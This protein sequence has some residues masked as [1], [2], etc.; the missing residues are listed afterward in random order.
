[1]SDDGGLAAS[2]VH[3][4]QR[5]R[6]RANLSRLVKQLAG[7]P[8]RLLP[9]EEV[10]RRLRAVESAGKRL[11]DVPLDAIVGSVGRYNDF[12]REFLPRFDADQPRWVGVKMAM[13]GL[14]G[15]PPIDLYRLGDAYFVRDGNHR[16]SVARQ[17]GAR[18]IQAYVT[19][20][21]TRVPYSPHDDPD[22]LI[23][24][25][26]WADFLDATRLDEL[27]PGADLEV[28]EPGAYEALLEHISVHRYYMGIDEDREVGYEEA[29]AHW[30][31][32]IY[33]PL[34]ESI[35]TSGI[36][37]GFPGRTET[38]LYLWL[39]DHRARV[40]EALGWELPGQQV[41][42]AVAG[43]HLAGAEERGALLERLATDEG[44]RERGYLADDL[45]VAFDL[46]EAGRQA[47]DQ[48]LV[49]AGRE[50][51]RVYGLR[52]VPPDAPP[53]ERDRTRET[54]EAACR[55]AGVSGQLALLDGDPVTHI[56]ERAA[57]VD[58]V[59][60]N[61]AYDGGAGREAGLSTAFRPLL[62]RSPRPLLALSGTVTDLARP[63]LA[64][65][66]GARAETALFAAVYAAVKWGQTPV[67]T[68]VAEAGRADE[69]LARARAMFERY[70]ASAD[71]VRTQG[72]VADAIVGLAHER[73]CDMIMMGSYRYSRLLEQVFGGVL[74]QVLRRAG[75]PVLIT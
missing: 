38:D 3:D 72:P 70:G 31:D 19:P 11:E 5:A 32:A 35:R 12:T 63:L 10:R 68:C 34:V 21:A 26:E 18:T 69:V 54:F 47:L 65:D 49:L 25:S 1:M 28:T 39:A 75:V 40:E 45:L 64:Y 61:L 23:L 50:R 56:L 52:V 7:G 9:Y 29:V 57:W 4:F 73:S 41:V 51:A 15:V 67:V 16:V 44:A 13:T 43:G 24:K 22:A 2:A 46:G 74:E 20:V 14:A 27:R 60:A 48:A 6:R 59:I 55:D 62:R 33:R 37:R 53:E 58:V 30:H 42:Q 71:Y 66:G 8:T 36:L 17:L